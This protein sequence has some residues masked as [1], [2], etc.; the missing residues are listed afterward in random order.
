MENTAK[1]F[2]KMLYEREVAVI[3]ML[4]ELCEEG[5]VNCYIKSL[6]LAILIGTGTPISSLLISGPTLK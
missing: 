1:D 6:S 3:V 5:K 4:S 2:W